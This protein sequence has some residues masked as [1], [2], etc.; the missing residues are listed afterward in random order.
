MVRNIRE[1]LLQ[2][3]EPT[4]SLDTLQEE[5]EVLGLDSQ[6]GEQFMAGVKAT[7]SLTLCGASALVG[8]LQTF[9]ASQV[10]KLEAAASFD[11]TDSTM[12]RMVLG[13]GR[14]P[15]VFKDETLT[16]TPPSSTLALLGGAYGA[17]EMAVKVESQGKGG[18]KAAVSGELRVRR[19]PLTEYYPPATFDMEA[20]DNPLR[21]CSRLRMKII[22][23]FEDVCGHL[24]PSKEERDIILKTIKDLCGP[25][26][27]APSWNMYWTTSGNVTLKHKGTSICDLER[28]RRNPAAYGCHGKAIDGQMRPARPSRNRTGH[29]ALDALDARRPI[30]QLPPPHDGGLPKE[31]AKIEPAKAAAADDEDL[32]GLHDETT[33]LAQAASKKDEVEAMQKEAADAKARTKEENAKRRAEKKAKQEAEKAEKNE[34]KGQGTKRG[35]RCSQASSNKKPRTDMLYH[36]R[37]ESGLTPYERDRAATMLSNEQML[38]FIGKTQQ[39]GLKILD[40][41]QVTHLLGNTPTR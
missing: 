19:A 9:S 32:E 4:E 23:E 12:L 36:D 10:N 39:A 38:T 37:P 2:P 24:Y 7:L 41:D 34:N 40:V 6:K 13:S 27:N 30:M 1:L 22:K 15:F 11:Q 16:E 29:V 26:D 35:G 20:K 8:G 14:H 21:S 5:L 3:I 28:A 18:A 17:H 33:L 31:P 25:P